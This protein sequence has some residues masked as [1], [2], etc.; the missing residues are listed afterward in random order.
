[1]KIEIYTSVSGSIF[2]K[3]LARALV[4]RGFSVEVISVMDED[5]YRSQKTFLKNF[6]SRLN[7]YAGMSLRTLRQLRQK[8]DQPICRIV[9]TNPFFLPDLVQRKTP[10]DAQVRVV[11]FVLDLYPEAMELAGRRLGLKARQKLEAVTSRA[12]RNCDASVFLGTYLQ[13]YAINK[14]GPAMETAI[15]PV[16]A[17]AQPF[18]KNLPQNTPASHSIRFLY[19]GHIGRMHEVDTLVQFGRDKPIMGC[20]WLFHSTGPGIKPLKR[21]WFQLSG[22]LSQL[23]WPAA[24][25]AAQ[26]GVVTI[27]PGAEKVVMPSKTYSALSSGQ[28]LLA[29]CPQNSDLATLI[30]DHDCG[31]VIEPGDIRGLRRQVQEICRDRESLLEKRRNAFHVG[32]A[33]YSSDQIAECWSNLVEKLFCDQ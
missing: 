33:Q 24:M 7:L 11:N 6:L 9:T 17:D 23:E 19:C 30:H 15:I 8:V 2:W 4:A 25:K 32:Q 1:M 27:R 20:E 22:P 12:I 16:G 18:A 14:Y 29:V 3:G 13:E 28:A 5:K 21:S 31:W 10:S 26:V